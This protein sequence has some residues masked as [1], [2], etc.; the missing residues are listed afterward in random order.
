MNLLTS[1]IGL[2]YYAFGIFL[3]NLNFLALIVPMIEALILMESAIEWDQKYIYTR[4]W[5]ETRPVT[6]FSPNVVYPF[7]LQVAGLKCL[8]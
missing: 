3:S 5:S 1:F 4:I 6:Y 7:I 2:I 8:I